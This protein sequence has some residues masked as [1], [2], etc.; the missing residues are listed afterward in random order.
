MTLRTPTRAGPTIITTAKEAL[1]SPGA[2]VAAVV[3]TNAAATEATVATVVAA[4]A[5]P[6]V[7]IARTGKRLVSLSKTN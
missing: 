2:L 6:E 7:A 5:T 1:T 4:A 3:T